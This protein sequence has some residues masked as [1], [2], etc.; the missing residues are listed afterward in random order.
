[1]WV[2]VNVGNFYDL[3]RVEMPLRRAMQCWTA[4][5]LLPHHPSSTGR[6]FLCELSPVCAFLRGWG[7]LLAYVC[8]KRYQEAHLTRW[9]SGTWWANYKLGRCQHSRTGWGML[10]CTKMQQVRRNLPFGSFGV[11]WLCHSHMSPQHFP[12]GVEALAALIEARRA[13]SR[14]QLVL[15]THDEV[16][17]WN[18]F[19]SIS[20]V[21]QCCTSPAS[22]VNPSWQ[23][24]VNRLAQLQVC[25][26]FYRIHKDEAW[27]EILPFYDSYQS[28]HGIIRSACAGFVGCWWLW[29]R[30]AHQPVSS[31]IW[32]LEDW[33]AKDSAV[34]GLRATSSNDSALRWS[35]V[36]CP[37]LKYRTLCVTAFV[38][39]HVWQ[40]L[41]R[42]GLYL[43]CQWCALNLDLARFVCGVGI[44][45]SRSALDS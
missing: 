11:S 22:F 30:S 34:W 38:G 10:S 31:G 8:V 43:S 19:L 24:F 4:R 6:F 23:V 37:Q 36:A 40:Y 32:M 35:S 9:R 13:Q 14:F 29:G 45:S 33:Q 1:M 18:H 42:E 5:A 20:M 26:W 44:C 12:L 25:D 16:C 15:I 7:V 17:N 28:Y 39:Y 27:R 21:A 41:A 3:L 2:N